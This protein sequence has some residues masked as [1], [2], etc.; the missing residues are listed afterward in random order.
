[1]I[2]PH[3]ITLYS[4]D[5]AATQGSKLVNG[6][7]YAYLGD[8]KVIVSPMTQRQV[9]EQIGFELEQPHLVIGDTVDLA[10]VKSGWVIEYN[11]E[12]YT[13]KTPLSTWSALMTTN[14]S[15]FV[16]DKLQY[17]PNA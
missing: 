5:Q 11:A 2:R 3:T 8:V 6:V 13:V 4:A 12:L 17:Q 15:S 9:V 14:H 10:D 7:M 16:M 1:M